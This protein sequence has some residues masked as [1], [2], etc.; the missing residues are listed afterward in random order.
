MAYCI[1]REA[2]ESIC[3]TWDGYF[4]GREERGFLGL[5]GRFREASRKKQISLVK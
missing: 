2:D 5:S 1:I 4:A 3:N